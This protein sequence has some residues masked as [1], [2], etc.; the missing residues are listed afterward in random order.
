[1][2]TGNSRR[3]HGVRP[4]T[5]NHARSIPS[6]RRCHAFLYKR[7][8]PSV[9]HEIQMTTPERRIA[10]AVTSDTSVGSAAGIRS[11]TPPKRSSRTANPTLSDGGDLT[12][13]CR[14]NERR[15]ACSPSLHQLLGS[16]GV[17]GMAAQTS[18]AYGPSDCPLCCG[19]G[20]TYQRRHD[21]ETKSS[22]AVSLG[23]AHGVK[24]RNRI[25]QPSTSGHKEGEEK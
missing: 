19:S 22:R 2:H 14:P 9:S 11:H 5:Y 1:M 17:A 10:H 7:A 15:T 8:W 4:P 21:D 25:T 12:S 23:P 18:S 20:G 24:M 6:L 3:H 16:G 13:Q